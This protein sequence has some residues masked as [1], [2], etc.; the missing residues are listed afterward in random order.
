MHTQV[1]QRTGLAVDLANAWGTP[2]SL[3]GGTGG[4]EGEGEEVGE[5]EYEYECRRPLLD[6]RC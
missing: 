6:P 5:Y 4:Q 2:G 1:A 3:A